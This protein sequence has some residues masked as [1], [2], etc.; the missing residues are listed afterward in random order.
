MKKQDG[1][2]G[3]EGREGGAAFGTLRRDRLREVYR[4][5]ADGTDVVVDM[6]DV[7]TSV[8]RIAATTRRGWRLMAV[9][10]PLALADSGAREDFEVLEFLVNR[11]LSELNG[12]KNVVTL[13]RH[14]A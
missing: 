9:L 11:G 5:H 13:A 2:R 14:L 3:P 4:R 6:E 12:I 8:E 7:R 10:D 1:C